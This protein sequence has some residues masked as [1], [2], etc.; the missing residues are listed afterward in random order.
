MIQIPS[1]TTTQL[2][3]Q[4]TAWTARAARHA[5]GNSWPSAKRSRKWMASASFSTAV[6]DKGGLPTVLIL[7]EPIK[8]RKLRHHIVAQERKLRTFELSLNP[9]P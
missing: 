5:S 2:F 9:K 3:C 1:L 7:T 4:T 6:F 8:A